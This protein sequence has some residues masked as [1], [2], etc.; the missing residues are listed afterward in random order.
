MI[1]IRNPVFTPPSCDALCI[2]KSFDAQIKWL[3]LRVKT[4]WGKVFDHD[5][6][7]M[8]WYRQAPRPERLIVNEDCPPGFV[9]FRE[10]I[11]IPCDP[12]QY[13][14][15]R[16]DRCASCP[17]DTFSDHGGAVAC[18]QCPT[19]SFTSDVA[20]K[21]LKKCVFKTRSMSSKTLALV[22]G[23][24]LFIVLLLIQI[25]GN[26]LLSKKIGQGGRS[27]SD[28]HVK[29]TIDETPD[30]KTRVDIRRE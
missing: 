29:V 18:K 22:V 16:Q 25:L 30:K 26:L 5:R 20:A 13:W 9:Y 7:L 3:Q 11:C 10:S 1:E 6:D 2:R 21:E 23:I 8:Y 27:V 28:R 17:I 14:N 24:P 15:E 4:Q 12:G 19:G